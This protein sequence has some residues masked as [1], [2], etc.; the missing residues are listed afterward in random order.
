MSRT[1]T[2]ASNL[3]R[4]Y[5]VNPLL[6]SGASDWKAVFDHAAGLGF[7][8]VLSAPLF[9]RGASNSVFEAA[10]L[11]RTDPALKLDPSIDDAVAALVTEA[12]GRD[13][14]FM[15]DLAIHPAR[16]QDRPPALDPRAGPTD[17]GRAWQTL[18]AE[19]SDRQLAAWR[20]RIERF[21]SAGVS[22][23][24]CLGLD[25]VP[26]DIWAS[27]MTGSS[28]G[29]DAADFFAF[30]PGTD[31]A[32]RRKL[33][34]LEFSG[35]FSSFAWWD[36]KEDW[37]R[38]EF[39]LQQA[40][41]LQIH[42]PE[43]PYARR[44]AH[45][46]DGRDVLE[47]RSIRA[48]TLAASLGGGVLV[49]M[50]FEF[51]ASLPLDP[52]YGDGG[53]LRALRDGGAFDLSSEIRAANAALAR[54]EA[55]AS[56]PSIGIDS[57]GPLTIVTKSDAADLRLA[58]SM[59]LVV[60]N[61]DLRRAAALPR[62]A[63]R[64][65]AA[66]FLPVEDAVWAKL[67]PGEIRRLDTIRAPSILASGAEIS[68]AEAAATPRIAIEKIA[69]Q[70]DDGRFP[71]KR[72]VGDI[73]TVEADIF[74]DGHDALAA[75]VFFRAEDEE[76]W[77]ETRM[78]LVENDRWRT[79][80][81]LDRNGRYLFAVEAWKNPFAIYRYELGK[82][83]EA[84]LDLRLELMEGEALVERAVADPAPGME[85]VARDELA[86]LLTELRSLDERRRIELLLSAR[87]SR[88]MDLADRRPFRVRSA[89][90]P[91]D[92][93]RRHAAFA[94]WYQI[95]PR[96]QSGD[97][98][99]HGTFD[100]VIARLPAI[101]EMGFDVLYF[102][103]I[104]PIGRTN[105]KGRN[106][107]LIAGP[108]DPGSPYAIGS[109]AGG[110]D[111][112][113]PELG[114]FEDF[115]RLVKTAAEEGLEIALDLAIQASPD[116]P[117]LTQ[118]PGWFDWRPDGTIRYA[119]NPPKK[120]EDIVN[121]DFYAADAV[122]DLWIE[123]R[124]IV[125]MWIEQGVFLFRVD[126]P[127]TKPLPFWEWLIRDIRARHPEAVFLS[128]AFTRPK[129]MYRLAKVGFSQSYTYFTWRNSK[130]ELEQYMLELTQKEP[131]EFFRPHFFVNTHDI[132]PDFLQNAPRPAFLIRAALAATLSGLWGVYNGF[133]LC[134][135]RPDAKRKEYADSE[136]YEIRA[137]DYDR[138]GN[139]K[140]E[141]A[142]LNRIRRQN[143]AL[144]SHLGLTLLNASNGN[145]LFFEK[146][147]AG[148]HN[149]LLIAINLDPSA[150]Q[151]SDIE[152]PLWHFGMDDGGRLALEDL[153][154]GNKFSFNGKWQKIRLDPAQL[155]FAIWRVRAGEV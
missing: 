20:E 128:E 119:E 129:V 123:L 65:I 120:Y 87:A 132:N 97:P 34:E 55:G 75:A 101:R 45:G 135:G 43:A 62:H 110:H 127:H 57:N 121:V 124:D 68:A 95:F 78:V 111:A 77:R 6:L 100:D 116:H 151:E 35:C 59:E 29:V 149:V 9:Q 141:I 47:R 145:V 25:L 109:E 52:T 56:P 36:L 96:S 137:W 125:E 8:A 76:S 113:H 136:K 2:P 72:V 48:L 83:H 85:P 131:R 130:W 89:P 152:I 30:T 115:R 46:V 42:A 33:S 49:P 84:R 18:D 23:F 63:L 98:N 37:F 133:E 92:A 155:P 104:H 134:E 53:G 140:A 26:P 5:Y 3:P 153:I 148:R 19:A 102:P 80:F 112:I 14:A 1:N 60:V 90:Y 81:P 64:E 17:A 107:S 27:L 106:N 16:S 31:F 99:R 91:V 44:L 88:L 94:S 71:V 147:S 54:I 15:L 32:L 103:P 79:S 61:R 41:G 70:V 58:H 122:P 10:D 24:R 146:A 39:L 67:L 7:S 51:G 86:A 138:P 13:L 4:I 38:E 142:M 105:R 154:G 139:I 21:L 66:P 69:P 22:G 117:W 82:K 150:V 12:K 74:A 118:H 108:N 73:V 11:D 50:G 40:F 126:N 143:P 28:A 144:Q 114:T 93:E